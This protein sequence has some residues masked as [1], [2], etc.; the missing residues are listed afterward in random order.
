[1]SIDWGEILRPDVPLIELFIRG[2]VIYLVAFTLLRSFPR[3]SGSTSTTDLLV[4]VFIADAAQNGMSANYQSLT[5]G[6]V[7]MAT[8]VFWSL[9]MNAAA[10]RWAWAARLMKPKPV[11]LIE[12]GR[13]HRRN[14]RRELVTEEELRSELRKRGVHDLADVES[15]QMESDGEISVVPKETG[16]EGQASKDRQNRQRRY[17]SSRR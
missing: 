8:I 1:M 4:L 11:L 15:V 14:M 6:L 5:D 9:A 7:L 3:E 12:G 10:Y 16:E 13:F 17:R 2:S